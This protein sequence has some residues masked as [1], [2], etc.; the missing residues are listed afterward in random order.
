MQTNFGRRRAHI[1]A[2]MSFFYF[3]VVAHCNC[4]ARIHFRFI[5]ITINTYFI[6][7]KKSL[8]G[9]SEDNDDMD[10]LIQTE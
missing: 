3:H 10:R 6:L 1:G 8:N 2:Y 4:K 9:V 7:L 5:I